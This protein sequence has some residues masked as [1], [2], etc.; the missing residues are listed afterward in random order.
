MGDDSV[1]DKWN[2]KMRTLQE[3]G[4][5]VRPGDQLVEANGHT[6]FQKIMQTLRSHDEV[7]LRFFRGPK[8]VPSQTPN[9]KSVLPQD[10]LAVHAAAER[11][12]S[13]QTFNDTAIKCKNALPEALRTVFGPEEIRV[14]TSK[15]PCLKDCLRRFVLVEAVEENYRPVY[16]C[17][18][19]GKADG[20]KTFA[21]R[22]MWLWPEGLP[23]VLTVHLKRFRRRS[24]RYDK[25][26]AS[27][28]LPLEF[29]ISEFVLQEAELNRIKLHS[30]EEGRKIPEMKSYNRPTASIL[31]YE[32][33]ALCEHQGATMQSGHYIAYVNSGPSLECEQWQGISDA[34]VWKCTRAEVL[35]AEAYV[36]FYRREG[37]E[38][39]A[40]AG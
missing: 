16:S 1:L 20:Q 21:S 13:R 33:Y 36:A 18:R 23:P 25:S 10:D 6:D 27:V 22:R 2:H 15:T 38:E 12:E 7:H 39:L 32:L 4:S 14:S 11:E 5:L 26:H 17:T 35:G 28:T 34:R 31:R 9:H 19:C 24:G 30:Q 8:D 40:E 29:D 3:L 37:T